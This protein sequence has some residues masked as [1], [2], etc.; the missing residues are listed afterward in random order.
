MPAVET[1]T[2]TNASDGVLRLWVDG[3]LQETLVGLDLD[4]GRVDNVRF[5]L[6]GGVDTGTAGSSFFDDFISVRHQ[7]IGPPI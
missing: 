3:V 7:Y 5:G 6:V 2:A 4:D 1:L